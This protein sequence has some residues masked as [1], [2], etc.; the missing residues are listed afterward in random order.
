[1]AQIVADC[2]DAYEEPKPDWHPRKQAYIASLATKSPRSLAVSLADKTH[3]A[4]AINPDL[5]AHGA[6]EWDRF[7]GR[8]DGTLLYYRSLSDAFARLVPDVAATRFAREVAE[9][10]ELTL[11]F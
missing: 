2:T 6:A 3:N 7:T 4:A 11:R 1:V 9:M 10:E 8:R 5:R